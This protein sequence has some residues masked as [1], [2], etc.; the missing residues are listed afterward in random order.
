MVM[1][2]GDT[3]FSKLVNLCPVK[4]FPLILNPV[5]A[6]L[7]S[8]SCC[9]LCGSLFLYCQLKDVI[10]LRQLFLNCDEVL[11]AVKQILI[12]SKQPFWPVLPQ[13]VNF[14]HEVKVVGTS[15]L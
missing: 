1:P 10:I 15:I 7:L 4:Y 14:S 5:T 2:H 3:D 8:K 12:S 13:V 11:V 6:L 9:V